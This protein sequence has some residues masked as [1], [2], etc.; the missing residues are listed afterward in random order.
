MP[1][2]E[3]I[4]VALKSRVFWITMALLF[5]SSCGSFL[6]NG[7][8]KTYVK[9]TIRDDNFLTIIGVIGCVGNGCTRFFWS[10]FYSKTGFKTVLLTIMAIQIIVFSTI[11]FTTSQQEIYIIEIFLANCCI[12]GY[13]VATPTAMQ[14]IYG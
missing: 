8:Y 11:K 6:L 2:A 4:L 13:L 7:N 1:I 10:L 9:K 3:S 5:I 12:G 14:N